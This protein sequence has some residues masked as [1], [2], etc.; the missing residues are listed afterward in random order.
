MRNTAA[1]AAAIA[2]LIAVASG[3]AAANCANPAKALGVSRVIEIDTSGGPIFGSAT[4]R[5]KEPR[6]LADHEVVLTFDDGPVPWVTKPILDTLDEFCTKATFFSVGEMALSYPA[7]TKEVLARGHTVGTHTWSHPNNLRR[8]GIEKAKDEI[9][10]G[11]AAVSLAAATDIAPFFRFP[12]LNDSDELL[13]YLQSRSIASF[14]VD[15]ISN[16]SFIGSPQRIADRTVKLAVAQKGGILLFHDLKRPTAKALPAILAG[17]KAKGFKVVHLIA[18]S[19]VVPLAT[20]DAE[21]Q[22]ILAKAASRDTTPFHGPVPR[23]ETFDGH[24]PATSELA[25]PA[26]TR[27]EQA[28][29]ATAAQSTSQPLRR[30]TGQAAKSSRHRRSRTR[31]AA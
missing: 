8:L 2:G 4:K 26:R 29:P 24:D 6:F 27:L 22:P 13:T 11:F 23:P 5:E 16:D 15:V 31:P 18:K 14:T 1:A 21:L 12:G 20:I 7:M 28:P 17:L 10:R 30:R 3:P 9:E 25:P 19:P